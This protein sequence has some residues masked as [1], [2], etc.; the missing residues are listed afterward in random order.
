MDQPV[1]DSS[2]GEDGT[3]SSSSPSLS[4]L[5]IDE[6]L[7][8]ARLCRHG[9][10][11]NGDCQ[12]KLEYKFMESRGV[13]FTSW[14]GVMVLI[15]F[16]LTM[17]V[18]LPCHLAENG[19]FMHGPYGWLVDYVL[20][21]FIAA[22]VVIGLGVMFTSQAIMAYQLR[23]TIGYQMQP[24]AEND[25][26]L[27]SDQATVSVSDSDHQAGSAAVDPRLVS[28]QLPYLEYLLKDN[29]LLHVIPGL[30]AVIMLIALAVGAFHSALRKNVGILT[31]ILCIVL[32]LVYCCVPVCDEETGESYVG[33]QK[34][35][36]V[37]SDP[38]V[39]IIVAHAVF[40]VFAAFAIPYFVVGS[41]RNFTASSSSFAD[42]V[43]SVDYHISSP[44]SSSPL[45][46]S[47]A[48]FI[49]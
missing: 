6:P 49:D 46:L 3:A 14:S 18:Y 34:M 43:G 11:Y 45:T 40:T 37:Y 19:K 29:F 23:N 42:K 44:V 30:A 35:K 26:Y 36:Y 7:P 27:D 8:D 9:L 32:A 39:W 5:G 48:R 31:V 10:M 28:L 17:A 41:A 47:S 21:P 25:N 13:Y 2:L 24:N 16:V 20:T 1:L 33:W 12:H 15:A 4:A 22:A 38:S